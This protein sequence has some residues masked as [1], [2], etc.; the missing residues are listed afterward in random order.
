[1]PFLRKTLQQVPAGSTSYVLPR[2]LRLAHSVPPF[3]LL[4]FAGTLV[5]LSEGQ[6]APW[7]LPPW[8]PLVVAGAAFLQGF[9]Y[10]RF[11]WRYRV[12]LTPSELLYEDG[13]RLRRIERRRIERLERTPGERPLLRF[14]DGQT[15]KPLL[16][17]PM[18][19]EPD[20][21]FSRFLKEIERA[22]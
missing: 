16:S 13:I 6:A 8:V 10:A 11:V 3:L 2:R 22:R 20:E 12:T 18:F 14:F 1:M 17:V 7:G 9:V 19:F 15:A 21:V 4:A 5:A